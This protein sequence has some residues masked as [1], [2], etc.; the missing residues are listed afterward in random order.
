MSASKT[1]KEEEEPNTSILWQYIDS[2]VGM[3]VGTLIKSEHNE[4]S[5]Q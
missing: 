2:I 3:I 5:D 1:R 4:I